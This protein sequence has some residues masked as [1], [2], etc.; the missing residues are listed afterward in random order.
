[1]VVWTLLPCDKSNPPQPREVASLGEAPARGGGGGAV[2]AD[3]ARQ[4]A[5]GAVGN[6]VVDLP[7]RLGALPQHVAHEPLRLMH[8]LPAARGAKDGVV[9]HLLPVGH[10]DAHLIVRHDEQAEQ[11]DA[12]RLRLVN[13]AQQLARRREVRERASPLQNLTKVDHRVRAFGLLLDEVVDV[14]HRCLLKG[15][16]Q[17][18]E[19]RFESLGLVGRGLRLRRGPSITTG[20]HYVNRLSKEKS[21]FAEQRHRLAPA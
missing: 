11:L 20:A 2:P 17:R 9:Q 16:E 5:A 3:V 19:D 12:Q 1:M 7:E 15:L 4:L 14:I 21:A 8:G 18:L 6:G 10:D 13:F